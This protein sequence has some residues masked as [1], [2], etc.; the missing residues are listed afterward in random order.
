MATDVMAAAAGQW[1]RLLIELDALAPEQLENRHQPCPACG[2][3]DRYRWDRDDGPGG[4]F[5]NQCGGRDQRGGG[6]SGMDLLLR[7]TGWDFAT[8]ARRIEA[9]LAL[10]A[11]QAAAPPVP[12]PQRPAST[13]RKAGRPARIPDIPPPDATPPEL[14]RASGQWCYTD[15]AGAP[16]FW[17][18]RL[19]LLQAGKRRKVFVQR[20]WLDGAGTSPPA[21]I[22]FAPTGLP[23]DRSTAWRSW[24]ATSGRRC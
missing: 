13:A 9:H 24:S 4:W 14:R 17:V 19:D 7:L 8:A 2:G 16:L 15:A 23:P 11:G 1:P 20:T 10:P 18:Q 21:A 3:T 12:E 5:C 6:G 22:R